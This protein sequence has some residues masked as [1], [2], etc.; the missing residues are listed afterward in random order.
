MPSL[1][2]SEEAFPPGCFITQT[3]E[4]KGMFTLIT[5][6]GLE[7]LVVIG[8]GT[9][10]ARAGCSDALCRL[11]VKSLPIFVMPT[12]SNRHTAPD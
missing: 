9:A 6:P 5:A 2:P 11:L 1:F 4:P 7:P 10:A 12:G 3:F 8:V